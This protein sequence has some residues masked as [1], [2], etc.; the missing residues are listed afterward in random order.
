[1][2]TQKKKLIN[3]ADLI[4]L[5]SCV[6]RKRWFV[7]L[8]AF[9]FAVFGVVI[10]LSTVRQYTVTA[11]VAPESSS[12][13]LAGSGVGSLASMVGVDL[14]I[15]DGGEA[16]YPLLYPDIVRSKPFLTSLFNVQ[17]KTLDETCD[18]TYYAYIKDF[19]KR[20]WL[21]AVKAFP[22]KAK[23]WALKVFSSAPQR[24]GNP[25]GQIMDPYMLSE[26]EL[27]MVQSLDGEIEIF[28][29]KKTNVVTLSFTDRDPLV[30]AIM[31]DTIM[32]R[33]QQTITEYRTKKSV[34][35]CEYIEKMYT[36]SKAEFERSQARYA[37]FLDSNRNIVSEYFIAER[38]RLEADK[39]LKSGLY[40]HWA[41]KLQLAKAK[42]QENTPVYVVLEPA[43]IP[44]QPSSMGR[45]M[46]V[47]LFAFVGF[48][49]AVAYVILKE[50]VLSKLRKLREKDK[51]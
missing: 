4:K 16:L 47:M 36:D 33:L 12:S 44:A 7:L 17:V 29:D 10:A 32:N 2:D 23:R 11:S 34:K 43:V 50:P 25:S 9:C 37:D 5:V 30:A 45:A 24:P 13:S 38:E 35:D 28:V 31:A 14:G 15:S 42:V 40:S 19:Q 21:D 27:L 22:K 6:W 49:L 26:S 20:T 3:E 48:V 8:F 1:M 39:E 46:R 51:E 41:Q 18:T